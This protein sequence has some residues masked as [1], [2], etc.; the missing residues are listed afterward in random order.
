MKLHN[1]SN[2]NASVTLKLAEGEEISTWAEH[3]HSV[4]Q[5]LLDEIVEIHDNGEWCSMCGTYYKN[6]DAYNGVDE[7]CSNALCTFNLAQKLVNEFPQ[8]LHT[9]KT[10]VTQTIDLK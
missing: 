3:T 4:L 6:T 5:A 2:E 8:T 9:L 10:L 1:A 7:V